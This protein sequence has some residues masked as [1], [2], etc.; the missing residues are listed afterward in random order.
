MM[1]DLEPMLSA[2]RSDQNINRL[3]NSN[4]FMQL[5]L[6]L[7]CMILM[8][9]LFYSFHIGINCAIQ[10]IIHLKSKPEAWGIS[11]IHAETKGGIC[12]YPSLSMYYFIDATRRNSQFIT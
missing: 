11:E 7:Y 3:S 2:E 1:D 9:F 4:P 10:V 8:H 12:G 5:I 6:I